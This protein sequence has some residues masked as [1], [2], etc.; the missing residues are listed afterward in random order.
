M[1]LKAAGTLILLI[2]SAFREIFKE[3]PLAGTWQEVWLRVSLLKVR[4]L[5]YASRSSICFDYTQTCEEGR[6]TI[7][8]AALFKGCPAASYSPTRSPAQYHRR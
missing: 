3:R 2:P 5:T 8:G 6:S 1:I 7:V 4:N